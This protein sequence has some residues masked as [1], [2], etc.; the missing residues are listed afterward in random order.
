M[1]IVDADAQRLRAAETGSQQDELLDTIDAQQVLSDRA[2]QHRLRRLPV[3]QSGMPRRLVRS[4]SAALHEPEL[5]NVTRERCL[6]DVEARCTQTAAEL[7]L[8]AH[9]GALDHVENHRLAA[10]LHAFQHT[11]KS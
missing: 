11:S 5:A 7:L 8:A 3:R 1:R 4:V 6:R 9:R 2:L 10:S